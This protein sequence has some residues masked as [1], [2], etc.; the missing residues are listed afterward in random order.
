MK[1]CGESIRQQRGPA[2][3]APSFEVVVKADDSFPAVPVE[4]TRQPGIFNIFVRCGARTVVRGV[5]SGEE[6]MPKLKTCRGAAKRF[7]VLKSGKIKRKKAYRSHIL[8]T[9][10]TKRKRKLRKMTLVDAKDV[11]EVRRLL[12]YG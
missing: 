11:R 10:T 2:A 8:T 9:K 3:A 4:S 12:P 7:T 5:E 1:S 6:N